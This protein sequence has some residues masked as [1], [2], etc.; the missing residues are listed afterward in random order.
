M[1]LGIC[2]AWRPDARPTESA[3]RGRWPRRGAV[4]YR[5]TY[6]TALIT[7]ASSANAGGPG[8]GP[9]PNAAPRSLPA[10]V[11]G[12]PEA[13]ID[14]INAQ[15][16]WGGRGPWSGTWHG[17]R[18]EAPWPGGPM[19]TSVGWIWVVANGAGAP[20]GV[21]NGR[22]KRL[23]RPA[24]ST[25]VGGSGDAD[26]RTA[27]D[28]G[29]PSRVICGAELARP[30]GAG[31]S[32][33]CAPAALLSMLFDCCGFDLRN[34]GVAVTAIHVGFVRTLMLDHAQHALPQ[35]SPSMLLS[36]PCWLGYLL[37]AGQGDQPAAAARLGYTPLCGTAARPARPAV[38]ASPFSGATVSD[39]VGRVGS[40]AASPESPKQTPVP[41]LLSRKRTCPENSWPFLL[42]QVPR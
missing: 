26:R 15:P 18:S 37:P 11:A 36:L 6:R 5:M 14:E 16:G 34:T 13:L 30:L 33:H 27:A 24:R 1:G 2:E 8:A 31:A 4:V 40:A 32:R 12:E 3:G 39:S 20:P 29:S 7:G 25:F 28:G 17:L 41:P 38:S 35:L 42:S 19:S 22:G 10:P 21:P 23:G 9:G